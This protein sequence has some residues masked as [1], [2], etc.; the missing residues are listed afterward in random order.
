MQAWRRWA[1]NIVDMDEDIRL[2]IFQLFLWRTKNH[3]IHTRQRS[4]NLDISI[5]HDARR[6]KGVAPYHKSLSA[7]RNKTSKQLHARQRPYYTSPR[8]APPSQPSLTEQ[9]ALKQPAGLSS[10]KTQRRW[11]GRWGLCCA[12]HHWPVSRGIWS[13]RCSVH[14]ERRS[15]HM[16]SLSSSLAVSWSRYFKTPVVWTS[17]RMRES[18]TLCVL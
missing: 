9:R 11:L 13:L 7:T 16:L 6:V 18:H 1:Y 4:V 8:D 2:T 15:W 12:V 5:P 17:K 3:Y 14:R 10:V